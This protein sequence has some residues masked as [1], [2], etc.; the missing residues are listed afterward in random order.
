M[1]KTKSTPIWLTL[2]NRIA[3]ADQRFRQAQ[4]LKSL[5]AYRLEDMGMTREDADQAFLRHRYSRPADRAA[6][7]IARKA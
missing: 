6:M 5:P 7:P 4:K 3:A 1:T 2:L